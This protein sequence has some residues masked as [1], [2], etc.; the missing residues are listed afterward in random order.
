MATIRI[1][2]APPHIGVVASVLLGRIVR[3]RLLRQR[4]NHR[5]RTITAVGQPRWWQ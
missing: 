2:G 4:A 5:R 3:A 1:I